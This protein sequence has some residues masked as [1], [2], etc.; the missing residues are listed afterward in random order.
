MLAGTAASAGRAR[1]QGLTIWRC[2]QVQGP[3]QPWLAAHRT[4]L[5]QV[6]TGREHFVYVCRK[7]TQPRPPDEPAGAADA[8]PAASLRAWS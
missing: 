3:F 5:S 4:L 7:R 8:V 2:Q 1:L 6:S